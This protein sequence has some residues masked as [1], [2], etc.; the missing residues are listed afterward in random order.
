LNHHPEY[1]KWCLALWLVRDLVRLT[2]E[3]DPKMARLSPVQIRRA[4]LAKYEERRGSRDV[5]LRATAKKIHQ[6][7]VSGEVPRYNGPIKLAQHGT[8]EAR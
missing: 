4:W 8:G 1:V 6:A 5:E 7:L 2:T 3:Q